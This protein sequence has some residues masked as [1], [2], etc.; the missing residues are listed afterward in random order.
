MT[1]KV[2]CTDFNDNLQ[3]VAQLMK[4]EHAGAIVSVNR[5]GLMRVHAPLSL[6]RSALL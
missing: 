5:A 2:T 6:L 4:D 3:H 1:A